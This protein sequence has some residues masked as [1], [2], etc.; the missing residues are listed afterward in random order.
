[1]KEIKNTLLC[2]VLW[3]VG[4]LALPLPYGFLAFVVVA[5]ITSL[6]KAFDTA[7]E[8]T[9]PRKLRA[10]AWLVALLPVVLSQRLSRSHIDDLDTILTAVKRIVQDPVILGCLVAALWLFTVLTLI[11]KKE[12][13]RLQKSL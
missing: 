12:K 10:L 1:M 3:T 7:E 8:A 11:S 13:Q 5:V 2:A 9:L 6:V 4:I